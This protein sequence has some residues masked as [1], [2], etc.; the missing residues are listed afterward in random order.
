M[1]RRLGVYLVVLF[2]STLFPAY[3]LKIVQKT[4]LH[5]Y[6]KCFSGGII[7]SLITLRILP[8]V[9]TQHSMFL[10]P[11]VS[12]VVFLTLF[13]LEQLLSEDTSLLYNK[14][15]YNA[16]LFCVTIG[17]Q[18]LWEGHCVFRVT[19]CMHKW[20]ILKLLGHKWLEGLALGCVVFDGMFTS[21]TEHLCIHIYALLAPLGA[22]LGAVFKKRDFL[23]LRG[24]IEHLSTGVLMGCLFY[25]GFIERIV[26]EFHRS[27]EALRPGLVVCIT[28]SGFIVAS[29]VSY[30]V[31]RLC[32]GCC[33]K[34]NSENTQHQ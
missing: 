25:V 30:A 29:F 21:I 20:S 14:N 3:S 34:T 15:K 24:S 17:I 6:L 7:L 23:C 33:G 10:A 31:E 4:V 16:V 1:K 2:A 32:G 22:G 13:S 27:S 19:K 11:F 18:S 12:G 5:S 9:Y 8:R 26:S 28:A